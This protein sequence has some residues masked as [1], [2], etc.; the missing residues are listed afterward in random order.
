MDL[1]SHLHSHEKEKKS[2]LGTIKTVLYN[3][4]RIVGIPDV[5]LLVSCLE[6]FNFGCFRVY[7]FPFMFLFLH[8]CAQNDLK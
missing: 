1:F 7:L 4:Q 5:T 6:S 2:P 3:S 8:D